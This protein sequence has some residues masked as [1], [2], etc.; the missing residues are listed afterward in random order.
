MSNISNFNNFWH[1]N[2]SHKFFFCKIERGVNFF[3]FYAYF[4]HFFKIQI[5]QKNMYKSFT[6]NFCIFSGTYK[7]HMYQVFYLY[8]HW[9]Y[10]LHTHFWTQSNGWSYHRWS[11]LLWITV[12]FPPSMWFPCK[13]V[14]IHYKLYLLLGKINE[15]SPIYCKMYNDNIS[16]AEFGI[17]ITMNPTYA[18]R[19]ELPENM[20]IQFRNVAM[21]VL[22]TVL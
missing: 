8:D 18:G 12:P 2:I 17:F 21:M 7:A 4:D 9:K 16:I 19:Q 22:S 1:Q 6:T 14:G 13:I 10:Y 3:S 11:V 15:L 20:K 5:F